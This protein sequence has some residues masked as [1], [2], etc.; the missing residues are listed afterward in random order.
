LRGCDA[1][2]WRD[3]LREWLRRGGKPA[4]FSQAASGSLR[5]HAHLDDQITLVAS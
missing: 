1:T 2:N 5:R 3:A 4:S